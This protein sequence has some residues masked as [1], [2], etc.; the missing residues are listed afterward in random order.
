[1]KYT[2]FL[3]AKPGSEPVF[4][5]DEW[6]SYAAAYGAWNE[7]AAK[8]RI[9]RGGEPVQ[10]PENATTIQNEGGRLKLKSGPFVESQAAI[11]GWYLIEVDD[12]DE[13]VKWASKIPLVDRGLGAVEIRPSVDF[14]QP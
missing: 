14:S 4:G 3:A 12:F 5:T 2:L 7:Q 8:A 6:K 1:M 9:H 10:P 13:A 11:V